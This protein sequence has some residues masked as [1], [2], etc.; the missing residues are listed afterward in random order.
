MSLFPHHG[1]D[2]IYI[3]VSNVYLDMSPNCMQEVG[4][5]MFEIREKL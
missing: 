5:Q 4:R 1:H 2:N 3:S